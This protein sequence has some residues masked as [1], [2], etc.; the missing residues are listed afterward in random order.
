MTKKRQK[1]W[2]DPQV[3]VPLLTAVIASVI[4]PMI[5]LNYEKIFGPSEA[6]DNQNTD[7][8]QTNNAN[9]NAPTSTT[10]PPSELSGIES[11]GQSNESTQ[12]TNGVNAKTTGQLTID[13]DKPSY[14]VRET[15]VIFGSIGKAEEGKTVR[16]DIRDPHGQMFQ[17]N[18]STKTDFD[19]NYSYP[20]T[21]DDVK[22]SMVA[23]EETM[24]AGNYTAMA[25]VDEQSAETKFNVSHTAR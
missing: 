18:L 19:G 14:V 22:E 20:V 5:L 15:A 1:R 10:T 17:S 4:G 13:S 2:S 21:L 25:T 6:K 12:T 16:I 24:V 9:S 23:G 7:T 11:G 3:L 8:T